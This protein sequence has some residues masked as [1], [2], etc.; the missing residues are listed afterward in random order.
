MIP[1]HV[2][3]LE[4]FDCTFLLRATD[5]HIQLLG[6]QY[7]VPDEDSLEIISLCF[8]EIQIA[9]VSETESLPLTVWTPEVI[10]LEV[11]LKVPCRPFPLINP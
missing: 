4:P 8:A 6:L 2:G 3:S 1:L 5:T 7:N 9:D 11:R 10:D